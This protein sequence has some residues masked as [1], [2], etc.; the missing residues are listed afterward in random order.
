MQL[1]FLRSI[2]SASIFTILMNRKI[3]YYMYYGIDK[4]HY[5]GL[6]IRVVMGLLALV[7]VYTAVKYLP[8]IYVSLVTSLSPLLT[9]IFSYFIFKKGLSK[10][11]IAVLIVSFIG[12]I[13]LI[14]GAL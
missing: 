1:L 10:L 6:L 12:V 14:T 5:R 9:A 4:K 2:T 11:D 3:P 7:S 8:L 13:I